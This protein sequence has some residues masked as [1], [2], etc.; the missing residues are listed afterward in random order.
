LKSPRRG[1]LHGLGSMMFGLVLQKFL[2]IEWF[3][4]RKLN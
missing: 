2:N 1:G 3:L 4:H